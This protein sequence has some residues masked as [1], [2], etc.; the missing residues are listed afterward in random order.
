MTSLSTIIKG[1]DEMVLNILS[2]TNPNPV[3]VTQDANL[4]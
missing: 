4:Q 2:G 3:F 1:S